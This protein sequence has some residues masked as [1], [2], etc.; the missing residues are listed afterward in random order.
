[1]QQFETIERISKRP[2]KKELSAQAAHVN[3]MA[4]KENPERQVLVQFRSAASK[5]AQPRG[6][7]ADKAASLVFTWN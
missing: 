5:E 3:S 1:M 6:R 4:E 7:G 2:S